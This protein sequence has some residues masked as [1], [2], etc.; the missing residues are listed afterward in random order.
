[1]PDLKKYEEDLDRLYK[2]VDILS[3]YANTREGLLRGHQ[4]LINESEQDCMAFVLELTEKASDMALL[5]W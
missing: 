3:Q 1:M 5:S 2:A 4:S